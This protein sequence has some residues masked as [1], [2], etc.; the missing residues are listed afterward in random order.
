[1]LSTPILKQYI[2]VKQFNM[3]N[4]FEQNMPSKIK[5]WALFGSWPA[6]YL[7]KLQLPLFAQ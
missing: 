5:K 1:M 2:I 4:S 6:Y 3:G 7:A